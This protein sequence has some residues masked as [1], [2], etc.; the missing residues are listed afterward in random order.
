MQLFAASLWVVAGILFLG[1]QSLYQSLFTI[2]LW[3]QLASQKGPL[4]H[5]E[6]MLSCDFSLVLLL[7]EATARY[8]CPWTVESKDR[9]KMVVRYCLCV[10]KH[11]EFQ[12][13]EQASYPPW[14][15]FFVFW[16]VLVPLKSHWRLLNKKPSAFL[17]R[18]LRSLICLHFVKY[19]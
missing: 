13:A 5:E 4:P 6:Q 16:S 19:F 3:D 14:L 1:S 18:Y 17:L 11:M 15:V 7:R 8:W 9:I 10:S 2:T 12:T